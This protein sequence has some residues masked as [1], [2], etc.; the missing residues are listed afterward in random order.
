M[1]FQTLNSI[2]YVYFA[3]NN[4]NKRIML[5]LA[6]KKIPRAARNKLHE[7]GEVMQL[8][9]KGLTYEAVSGHPDIFFCHVNGRWIVAPNLPMTYTAMLEERKINFVMGEL[10]VGDSY[11]DSARYNAVSTKKNLFHNFRYTDSTITEIAGDLDLVHISQ[12]YSRCNLLPLGNDCFI[13]SDEGIFRVLNNY[14]FDVLL[15]NPTGIL[16]PGFKHGFFGGAAGIIEDK[17]FLI[18]NLDHF[19]DGEKIRRH[20]A[21]N[22][23]RVIELY[24]GPLFDGGS[25]LFL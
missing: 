19:A 25:L 21:K 5:I 6:D 13:T 24:D 20:L 14:K 11:P 18:G 1:V 12:G 7:F 23:Y 15:V 4:S 3:R 9:T 17:V 10:P 16:L 22:H 8:E 2:K